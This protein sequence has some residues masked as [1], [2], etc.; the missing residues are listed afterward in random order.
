MTSRSIIVLLAGVLATSGAP[1]A[2]AGAREGSPGTGAQAPEW[3]RGPSAPPGAPN[4]LLVLLDDVGFG[5]TSTFGGAATTPQLDR[6]AA[7]GLSYNQFH[8]NALCSPTR[9]SLLTGRNAHQ[10]SFGTVVEGATAGPGYRSIWGREYASVAEVLRQNG[11]STAAIGKWHNTPPWEINPVGPFDRWPT[12]LGFEYFYGFQLGET[13]EWEPQLYR[14]TVAVEPARKPAEGYHLTTDLVDDAI[15]WLDQHEAIAAEKPWFLYFA[16]GATHA[17]HHVPRPWIA[18][19]RGKFDQGWDRLREETF[20]RQKK[21]GVIPANA[22]L[23]PRP[24]ELP[25]WDSL[26]ADQKRLYA[27]QMEVYAA[28]L[29]HTDHEVGRLLESVRGRPG[30]DDTLVLYVVGDNGGSAEGTP[31]GTIAN[32]AS[33]FGEGDGVQ[34]QLPHLDEL[35]SPLHDNHFAVAWAW[36]TT[37]PFQWM[38]QVASHF[39][40]VTNPLVVSWPARIKARGEIRSQ[41]GHVND[42]APTIYEL[43][44]LRFPE[45]VNGVR[46]VPLEGKSLAYSF[47]APS[48]PSRH[49]TQYFELGGHRSIYQDGWV[50]GARY[51]VPWEKWNKPGRPEDQRWELYHVSE[52]YSEAHDLAR[53]HPQKL[54]ELRKEFDAEATRNQVYP[55]PAPLS[56]DALAT[57]PSPAA[58]KTRFTYRAGVTRIGVAAAPDLSRRSHRITAEVEIPATGAEGVLIAEGGRHG[59]FTLYVKDRHLVYENNFF[60][61]HRDVLVSTVALPVGRSTVSFEFTGDAGQ[62]RHGGGTGRLTVDGK[63]AGEVRFERFGGFFGSDT[64]TLDVGEERGST[65]SPAY[66]APFRFTGK[67]EKVTVEL[68]PAPVS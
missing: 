62:K 53:T 47:D 4:V 39:G 17:P 26:S 66:E 59:G 54:A 16:T 35:G 49:T 44:G 41:F 32:F 52:D 1:A 50:A 19:Y 46:Q 34:R 30:G 68:D 57:R 13:S 48:V 8:T 64:E 28:Y 58:G 31:D 60:S 40:G 6:L 33:F 5:A 14:N 22:E 23:T 10:V 3:P 56:L 21:L 36:A 61:K 38:K 65:V 15:H 11:Y 27:R 67:L 29:E 25:A 63:P 37:T 42:I 2:A 20:A 18:K 51:G 55:L 9:A 24:S 7:A 45:T 12:S 43:V